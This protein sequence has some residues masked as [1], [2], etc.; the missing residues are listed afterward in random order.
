M[1]VDFL[2]G[3]YVKYNDVLEYVIRSKYVEIVDVVIKFCKY[4]KEFMKS[5][6]LI[7]YFELVVN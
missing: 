7:D 2:G 3:I 5:I 6:K 1:F 4:D